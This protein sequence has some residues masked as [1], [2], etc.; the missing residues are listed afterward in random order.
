MKISNAKLSDLVRKHGDFIASYDIQEKELV[1]GKGSTEKSD[2]SKLKNETFN[3]VGYYFITDRDFR[4]VLMITSIGDQ[5]GKLGFNDRISRI[6][7]RAT[8]INRFIADNN[9]VVNIMFVP[10]SKI[11]YFIEPASIFLKLKGVKKTERNTILE[12]TRFIKISYE[13]IDGR[14]ES[15]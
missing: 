6:N 13:L 1:D 8:S 10:P 9:R 3:Q 14:N 2:I 12:N 5:I 7:R 11:K 15:E 4:D